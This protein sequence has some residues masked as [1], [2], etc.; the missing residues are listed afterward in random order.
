M[1]YVCVPCI[2]GQGSNGR[3]AGV[4][5]RKKKKGC[6]ERVDRQSAVRKEAKGEVACTSER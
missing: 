2:E 1:G 4:K 6:K 3:E 5:R